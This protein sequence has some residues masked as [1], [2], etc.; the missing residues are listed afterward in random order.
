MIPPLPPLPVTMP[1]SIHPRAPGQGRWIAVGTVGEV[2]L[3]AVGAGSEPAVRSLQPP[4]TTAGESTGG[5][6]LAGF[7]VRLPALASL[8]GAPLSEVGEALDVEQL[9][10]AP[11]DAAL[12]VGHSSGH[13]TLW[14][15]RDGG[16]RPQELA[17]LHV[18]TAPPAST[19]PQSGAP[20]TA[21][22]PPAHPLAVTCLLW[23]STWRPL[24]ADV[25]RDTFAA[26]P[27]VAAAVHARD[28]P[29]NDA[30]GDGLLAWHWCWLVV[31]HRDGTLVAHA[32]ASG[33]TVHEGS[34][35]LVVLGSVAWQTAGAAHIGD[36]ATPAP[37]TKK[38]RGKVPSPPARWSPR[39][40][41]WSGA[42]TALVVL[43]G[44]QYASTLCVWAEA[45]GGARRPGASGCHSFQLA[46]R[47]AAALHAAAER[48]AGAPSA[49]RSG[50]SE[51]AG[52]R[53]RPLPTAPP[54]HEA[55]DGRSGGAS[56][57][58]TPCGWAEVRWAPTG[59]RATSTAMAIA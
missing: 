53:H 50:G 20:S 30:D 49:A 21:S 44:C 48:G 5:E 15:V 45:A 25:M 51:G 40:L 16:G 14:A 46:P 27:E 28:A 23:G 22:R 2:A 6:G 52:L 37:V 8:V 19:A 1:P 7:S 59:G 58:A 55:S 35:A 39:A 18:A 56:A 33:P 34:P 54:P 17:Y 57:D 36:R 38:G 32:V 4:A 12:A 26:P 42:S 43:D 29:A 24:T 3:L 41:C 10:W 13:V 31:G 47:A 9:A 11:A